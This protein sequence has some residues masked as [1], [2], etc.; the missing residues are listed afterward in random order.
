MNDQDVFN[1][2]LSIRTDILRIISCDWNIQTHARINS[3]LACS[4]G[5]DFAQYSQSGT[6]LR[7]EDIPFNCE[8]SKRRNIFTCEKRAKVL[9]FMAQSYKVDVVNAAS[10]FFLKDNLYLLLDV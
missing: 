2:V 9:H 4:R 1:A 5:I 7:F 10:L 6:P 3:L 8:E